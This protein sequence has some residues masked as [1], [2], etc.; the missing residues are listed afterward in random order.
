MKRPISKIVMTLCF[1]LW[2][3]PSQAASADFSFSGNM[4]T[5]VL[6]NNST[7][8]PAG[9]SNA[10]QLLTSVSFDLGGTNFITSGTATI[11]GGSNSVNFDA[12]SFSGGMN[13]SSEWGYGNG[14]TTGLLPNFVSTIAAGTTPFVAPLNS[15]NNLD[16]SDHSLSGPQG[17][18]T[19]GIID[20]GGTGGIQN[21]VTFA[22]ALDQDL[23]DLSF[24]SKGVIFEFGSDAK[25]LPVPEPGTLLLLGS[26]LIGLAAWRRKSRS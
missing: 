21:S 22:L 6:T 26:G 10:D 14:G 25:F 19:N 3:T 15:S 12:G 7:E 18:L 5:I 16:G 4:L 13:V 17:G 8:V 9:F 24:L 1:A 23:Q 2:A 20:L 11:T